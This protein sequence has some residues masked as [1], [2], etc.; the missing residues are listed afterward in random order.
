MTY[1]TESTKTYTN[2]GNPSDPN[3][4]REMLT[5]TLWADGERIDNF[6][7]TFGGTAEDA[8]QEALTALRKWDGLTGDDVRGYDEFV[9][10]MDANN[11]S[12]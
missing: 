1:L 10:R 12:L 8:R 7:E 2:P 6:S 5:V 3:N 4:G 11:W 9:R